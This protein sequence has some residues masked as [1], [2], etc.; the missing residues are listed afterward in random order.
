MCDENSGQLL[1]QYH[2]PWLFSLAGF[3]LHKSY[4][5]YPTLSQ[6]QVL[7]KQAFCLWPVAQCTT[8]SLAPDKEASVW[9]RLCVCVC[10]CVWVCVSVC[11]SACVRW[12]QRNTER[13]RET[14][15]W[16]G[17][18]QGSR[19]SLGD[20]MDETPP[21]SQYPKYERSWI[22]T[23]K[24]FPTKPCRLSQMKVI[25]TRGWI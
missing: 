4:F 5:L 13:Q 20:N 21:P 25:Y 9:T 23:A 15:K 24:F 22:I 10:V 1:G 18:S 17:G 19:A 7:V 8:T 2:R 12:W 11:V 3:W 14:E 16:G 6:E